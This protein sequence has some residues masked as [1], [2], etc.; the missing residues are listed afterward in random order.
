VSGKQDTRALT[1]LF[2]GHL[3]RM[4]AED[5]RG[6]TL[7]HWKLR[8]V[9]VDDHD[10]GAFGGL[11]LDTL[12]WLATV[13]GSPRVPDGAL[14]QV[15]QGDPGSMDVGPLLRTGRDR[16][17]WARLLDGGF[18]EAGQ[19]VWIRGSAPIARAAGRSLARSL[20]AKGRPV[21]VLDPQVS[22]G[23]AVCATFL[24]DLT[25]L[26]LTTPEQRAALQLLLSTQVRKRGCILS[27]TEDGV[28]ALVAARSDAAALALLRAL[29][30]GHEIQTA[31]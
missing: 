27:I 13:S 2:C 8:E 11:A 31:A 29:D 4:S 10:L 24:I 30:L 16:A 7:A 28:A 18:T 3:E 22:A 26:D 15:P 19:C 23:P 12:P 5:L 17:T 14:G 9:S 20:I 25:A 6:T 1:V 21:F